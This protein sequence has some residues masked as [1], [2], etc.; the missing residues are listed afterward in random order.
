MARPHPAYVYRRLGGRQ[1]YPRGSRI[2]QTL[3][4]RSPTP[5]PT[6]PGVPVVA[7]ANLCALERTTQ[8]ASARS[9]QGGTHSGPTARPSLAMVF[10]MVDARDCEAIRIGSPAVTCQEPSRLC[11]F[12]PMDD[13][14]LLGRATMLG[15]CVCP[16]A[17][18][19]RRLDA[20]SG[21]RFG[22]KKDAF[23]F[24]GPLSHLPV[25]REAPLSRPFHRSP[26]APRHR[27]R[28]RDG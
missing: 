10:D 26:V 16:R 19:T 3:V 15:S 2:R 24:L 20:L 28:R 4:E 22:L 13:G 6:F 11:E 27:G 9:R 23:L 1:K 14:P 17:G 18:D 5:K 12:V 21:S 8:D 7:P 25:G